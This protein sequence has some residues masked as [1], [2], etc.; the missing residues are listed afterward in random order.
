FE[1]PDDD[2][3]GSFAVVAR[4]EIAHEHV[5]GT[6][7]DGVD[8]MPASI[9]LATAD[10]AVLLDRRLSMSPNTILKI[11][12]EKLPKRSWDFGLIDCPPALGVLTKNALVCAD[13]VI[14]P[15][16]TQY[17][18]LEGVQELLKTIEAIREQLNPGLRL[19]GILA[20]RHQSKALNEQVLELLQSRFG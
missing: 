5:F 15:V 19:L 4:G 1:G 7:V 10:Q 3:S 2:A 16:E 20:C 6:N 17:M 13:A 12:L 11:A 9:S 8:L 14:V 18:P